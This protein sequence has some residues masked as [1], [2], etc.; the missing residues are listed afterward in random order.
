MLLYNSSTKIVDL[1]C[2]E[3]FQL[4]VPAVAFTAAKEKG[5]L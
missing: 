1:W 3:G 5:D 2:R 4:Q